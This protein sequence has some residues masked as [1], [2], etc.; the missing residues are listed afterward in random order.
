MF[1]CRNCDE[2]G[3]FTKE[4]PKPRDYSRIK[5]SN[6]EQ[7]KIQDSQTLNISDIAAVGHTK[8]RCPMPPKEEGADVGAENGGFG[9]GDGGFGAPETNGGGDWNAGGDTGNNAS[10]WGAEPS[11]A[12]TAW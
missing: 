5:C 8:V 7:S 10:S 3:H 4:C 1:T 11:G 9:N 6:C 2:K 12:A